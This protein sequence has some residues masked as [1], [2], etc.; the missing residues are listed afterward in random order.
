MIAT[1]KALTVKAQ[2]KTPF[3][4]ANL[5]LTPSLRDSSGKPVADI[6]NYKNY[7]YGLATDSPT[8]LPAHRRFGGQAKK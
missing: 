2:K 5:L 7:L 6:L 1:Y 8:P 4:P 3:K